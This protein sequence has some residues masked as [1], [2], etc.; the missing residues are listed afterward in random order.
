MTLVDCHCHI[1]SDDE[2]R[3]P[4]SPLGGSQSVWAAT[5]PITAEQMIERMDGVGIA[6][7]VLVQAT[8]A[9]GYDNQ[10]VIDSARRWPDRFIAVGTFDPLAPDAG[11]RLQKSLAAGLAGVRLFTTGS[12]IAHQGEWFAHPD[13]FPFWQ[14]ASDVGAPVSLQLRLDAATPQ[15]RSLLERFP[16]ATILLDHCGYPAVTESPAEAGKSLAT[17]AEHPGLHLKLT[18]RTL[19]GLQV[20]GNR[21]MEFLEPVLTEFTSR[22]IAWGSNCPAAEQPLAALVTLATDVLSPLDEQ[23]RA[24]ILQR[25]TLRLYSGWTTG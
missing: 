5:R 12:T 10:Y 3:Y 22:R 8:T 18:H 14:A 13:C 4:R 9:Y 20:L 6:Q 19:E 16:Q 7:S 11:D 24:D 25:T 2:V 17:L 23:A 15:L 1:I 21:A